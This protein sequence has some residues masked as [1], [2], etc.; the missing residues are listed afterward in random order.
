LDLNSNGA[1]TVSGYG[2]GG[3]NA[4]VSLEDIRFPAE[5]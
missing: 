5:A 2:T 1:L 4:F 3:S